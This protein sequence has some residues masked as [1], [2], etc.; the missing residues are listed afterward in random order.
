MPPRVVRPRGDVDYTGI[1][2]TEGIDSENQR[3]RYHKLF[4][5]DVLVTCPTF[6][7][8]TYEFLSSFRYTILIGGSRTTDTAYFR[9]F[10]RTYAINQDQLD[11]LLSSP[12]GDDFACQHP[13][14]SDL[15][16]SALDFW[17][18]LTGKTTTDW[19][20]LKATAIQNPAIRMHLIKNKPEDKYFLM[21]SNQEVR[22]VTLPCATCINVRMSA[23]WTFDL[24]TPEPDHMEQDVSHIGTQAHTA[25]SFPDS[26]T[27]T[28]SG[29][30]SCE[31]YD[32]T[33]MRT[34]LDNILSELR[35]RNDVEANRD[36]LLRNI[37][38]QHAEM[39]VSID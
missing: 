15:E 32:Y 14:E 6:I 21:I 28:S 1:V 26:F 34:T 7:R 22:R 2:F 23:N 24:N 29:H 5:R 20:G 12:R 36:V 38:M 19:E 30:Q 17:Q 3:S 31:K 39:R 4:K 33:A 16:S 9:M 27:G 8:L 11:D 35:H 25:P 13:L 18:Q 10:N 37:Q